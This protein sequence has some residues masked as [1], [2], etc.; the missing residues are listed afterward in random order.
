MYTNNHHQDRKEHGVVLGSGVGVGSLEFGGN[1]GGRRGVKSGLVRPD[2]EVR[3]SP[4]VMYAAIWE[5]LKV[6]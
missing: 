1:V 2:Q 4:L 3:V 5:P 6:S